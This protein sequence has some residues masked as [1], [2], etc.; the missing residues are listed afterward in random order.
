MLA[1]YWLICILHLRVEWSVN[2]QYSYGWAVPFLCSYLC[3]NRWTH[4]PAAFDSVAPTGVLRPVGLAMVFAA[5]FFPT[6]LVG[7]ANPDWRL[8]GWLFAVEVLGLT[9]CAIW[10]F[11]G[12][13]FV[14]LLWFPLAFFLISAPWLRTIE[15]PIVQSMARLSAAMSAAALD[16]FGEPVIWRRNVI[17]TVAGLVGVDEACSGIRSFQACLMIGLF[18]GEFQLLRLCPRLWLCVTAS[19]TAFVLN[20][21]RTSILVWVAS[22]HGRAAMDKWHDATG[23]SVLLG[24]LCAVGALSM[25]FA[26]GKTSAGTEAISGQ[27]GQ[28]G[29]FDT[30]GRVAVVRQVHHARPDWKWMFVLGLALW[31]AVVVA[32]TETWYRM[33]EQPGIQTVSWTIVWPEDHRALRKLPLSDRE[34]VLLRCDQAERAV[35]RDADGSHWQAVY[36]R[37]SSGKVWAQLI[38]DHSPSICLSA[39]GRTLLPTRQIEPISVR[40]LRFPIRTYKFRQGNRVAYTFHTLWEDGAT[41]QRTVLDRV[42]A[43]DRLRSVRQGKRNRGQ[44]VLEITVWGIDAL[45]R[46]EAAL[47]WQLQRLVRI[48]SGQAA[49]PRK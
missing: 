38:S 42:T 6:R 8:V 25:L 17:E 31:L 28:P 5:L 16:A 2:P 10:L 34:S 48:E 41:V 44:R 15:A 32:G 26:R 22:R 27:I 46:A 20:V 36:L 29:P 3:W 21:C 4:R 35:W 30:I 11:K 13:G 47:A 19:A 33:H 9:L 23:I 24:C 37:W 49:G 40:G 14:A 1:A 12:R 43:K 45:D 18:L 7:E 39:S